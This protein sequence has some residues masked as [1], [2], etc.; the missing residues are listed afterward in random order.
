MTD[1]STKRAEEVAK[2][3]DLSEQLYADNPEDSGLRAMHAISATLLRALA[4]E[5]DALREALDDALQY[6]SRGDYHHYLKP[7]TR[8]LVDRMIVEGEPSE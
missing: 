4:A 2:F 6:V 8:A 5:R 3:H 1:I 7:E